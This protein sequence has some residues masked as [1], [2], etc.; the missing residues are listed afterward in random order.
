MSS[1]PLLVPLWHFN[2][3]AAPVREQQGLGRPS[4]AAKTCSTVGQS[5]AGIPR[6]D[7]SEGRD[8]MS[9]LGIVLL[10]GRGASAAPKPS[11]CRPGVG[12][13]AAEAGTTLINMKQSH[14]IYMDRFFGQNIKSHTTQAFTFRMTSPSQASGPNSLLRLAPSF[15][16]RI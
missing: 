3:E 6:H 7:Q 12:R 9:G 5:D 14:Q 16:Y 2:V 10:A 13:G 11:P 1:W 8:V 15:Y 4:A